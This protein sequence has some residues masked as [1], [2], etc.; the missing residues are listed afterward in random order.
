MP[1]SSTRSITRIRRTCSPSSSSSKAICK[2]RA[3]RGSRVCSRWPKPGGRCP[4]FERSRSMSALRGLLQRAAAPSRRGRRRASAC[5]LRRRRRDTAPNASTPAATAARSGAPVRRD[6]AR[7]Q[8]GRRRR[9]V[10]DRR[11]E[12]G[13]D[14]PADGR[15]RQLAHQQQVDR[16]GE[17]DAAH[18]LVERVAADQDAVRLDVRDR[19]LPGAPS[20]RAC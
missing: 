10:V 9:A 3:A 13:R 8:R 16:V 6:V 12:N 14:H 4:A 7:H 20:P 18:H 1:R 5:T 2:R 11:D 15:R 17:A 19:G